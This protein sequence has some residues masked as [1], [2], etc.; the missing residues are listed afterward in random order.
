M[1]F[2]YSVMMIVIIVNAESMQVIRDTKHNTLKSENCLDKKIDD[3]K[4]RGFIKE[5]IV[6][7]EKSRIKSLAEKFQYP[8]SVLAFEFKSK[9]EF[10]AQWEKDG[11]LKRFMELKKYDENDKYTG[12]VTAKDYSKLQIFYTECKQVQF[13]ITPGMIFDVEKISNRYKIVTWSSVY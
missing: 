4:I 11:M 5:I 8:L 2:I 9:E 1:K 12:T 10:I 6:D 7:I 13:G 3:I